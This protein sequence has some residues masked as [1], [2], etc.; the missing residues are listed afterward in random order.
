[1]ATLNPELAKEW[2]PTKNGDLK[3]SM[4][5]KNANKKVWWK[6]S[7]KDCGHEWK[8]LVN[9]RNRKVEATGCPKCNQSKGEKQISIYLEKK[10]IKFK[11]QYRTKKCKNSNTLP[12]DFAILSKKE[13]LICLIEFDG[14]QHF[15]PNAMF[16]GEESFKK[17]KQNDEIKT[18]YCINNNIPLIR[19]PYWLRD[20]VDVVLDH[21]LIPLLEEE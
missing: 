17:T 10:H 14:Q 6:C 18:N 11:A 8:A 4:V 21:F 1:M 7:N 15:Y 16:G 9:S 20:Y 5:T 19:I 2:H 12:F 13:D 3:P